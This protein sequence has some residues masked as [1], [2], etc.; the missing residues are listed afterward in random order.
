MIDGSHDIGFETGHR[1]IQ[2]YASADDDEYKDLVQW[3]KK[4]TD[5]GEMSLQ[6]NPPSKTLILAVGRA[7]HQYDIDRRRYV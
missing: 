3:I 5:H 2:R 6:T 4:W 7:I 1:D